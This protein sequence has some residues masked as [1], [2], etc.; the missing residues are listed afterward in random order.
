MFDSCVERSI[1]TITEVKGNY[2][3]KFVGLFENAQNEPSNRLL[4]E[5][6]RDWIFAHCLGP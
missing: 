2:H 5:G 4:A 1:W 3:Q 6:Q